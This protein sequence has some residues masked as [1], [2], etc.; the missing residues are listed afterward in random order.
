MRFNLRPPTGDV[1]SQNV[2]HVT[3][4][5]Y[6]W[7]QWNGPGQVVWGSR[8][9]RIL[10]DQPVPESLLLNTP[11]ELAAC[12]GELPRWLRANERYAEMTQ[13]WPSL[14]TTLT[15]YFAILADWEVDD[16]DRLMAL[17]NWL[18]QNPASGLYPRQIPLAGIDTKWMGSRQGFIVELTTTIRENQL[19]REPEQVGNHTIKIDDSGHLNICG[20]RRPPSLVRL[21]VLDPALRARIGG[22][23]DLAALPTELGKITWF[24]ERVY[25]V[26]NLQ[27]ALAFDDL[28]GAIVI[29]G[30][31]YGVEFLS[32]IT[33]LLKSDC[34]YWGDIDTHGFAILN[35]ARS[36]LPSVSSILMDECTLQENR[37]L[38]VSEPNQHSAGS[39]PN[40][41]TAEQEL[42]QNLKS[43]ILGHN[44]RL[45]QERINWETAMQAISKQHS[46]SA[47]SHRPI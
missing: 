25:I 3:D 35:Q 29:F 20:L 45:E 5:I 13:A 42:Y 46:P 16:F 9:W 4:W 1:A 47:A 12:V 8:R 34:I 38:W 37:D 40:L 18:E 10:G 24:P 39:L 31:G 28:P 11:E 7:R 44:I 33:W 21:R 19:P 17:L 27:T 6:A 32:K 15:R 43:Q 30:S 41:T 36:Y 2:Q 22:L 26:E 23:S 14:H